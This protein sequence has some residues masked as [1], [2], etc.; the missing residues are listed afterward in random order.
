MNN[1]TS[2]ILFGMA[3]ALAAWTF[4]VW[5]GFAQDWLPDELKAGKVVLV[6]SNLLA[7]YPCTED[8]L[9]GRPDQVYR[10]PSGLHVPLENKNRDG[11]RVFESDIAQLSLQA[12]MLRQNGM[13]SAPFG[14]VAINSRANGKRQ[15]IRVDLRDDGYCEQLMARY[16]D[17]IEQR[18]VPRKSWGRKCNT[19]GHR[20]RCHA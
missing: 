10:L 14:Y 12:W 9:V 2:F 6:E 1:L 3:L 8:G 16:L 5:R 17:L 18:A 15:A 4:M 19:C 20:S 11:H 13:P 7:D